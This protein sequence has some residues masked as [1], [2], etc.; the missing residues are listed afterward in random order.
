MVEALHCNIY[1][2]GRILYHV[3][4]YDVSSAWYNI[5]Y[6]RTEPYEYVH[7][8]KYSGGIIASLE[9]S[10]AIAAA[11]ARLA[12]LSHPVLNL[13]NTHHYAFRMPSDVERTTPQVSVLS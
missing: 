9:S 6:V 3:I 13:G 4:R 10:S 7:L 1:N 12:R 2:N 11:A 8:A 5:L